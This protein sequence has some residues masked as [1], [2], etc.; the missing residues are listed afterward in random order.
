MASLPVVTIQTLRDMSD[1]LNDAKTPK[2]RVAIREIWES[3]IKEENPDLLGLIEFVSRAFGDEDKDG[4]YFF[5]ALMT[6]EILRI[7]SIADNAKL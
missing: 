7:Q 4:Y 3:R 2:E 6:Y 5:G 1:A